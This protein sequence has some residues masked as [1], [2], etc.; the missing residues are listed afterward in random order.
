MAAALIT[1]QPATTDR[2]VTVVRPTSYQRGRVVYAPAGLTMPVSLRTSIS[3]QAAQPG[4]LIE[5]ALSDAVSTGDAQIPL[6][7]F[8]SDR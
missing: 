5:A 6:V 8:L 4:D 1:A 7:R 2:V 3:T